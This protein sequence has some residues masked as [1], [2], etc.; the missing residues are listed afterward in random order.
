M[1]QHSDTRT[2]PTHVADSWPKGWTNAPKEA[3]AAG[4]ARSGSHAQAAFCLRLQVGPRLHSRVRRRSWPVFLPRGEPEGTVCFAI[5]GDA[6]DARR[7]DRSSGRSTERSTD[8][9]GASA[10]EAHDKQAETGHTA[11]E[12]AVVAT[13]HVLAERGNISFGLPVLDA[14]ATRFRSR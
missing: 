7:S 9:G 13:A 3:R 4:R 6:T 12:R 10:R 8:I 5:H 1:A 14:L 2:R 11:C